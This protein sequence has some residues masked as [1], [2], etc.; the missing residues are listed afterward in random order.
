MQGNNC[1]ISHQTTPLI[2]FILILRYETR[3]AQ[4]DDIGEFFWPWDRFEEKVIRNLQVFK[5]LTMDVFEIWL[6]IG[7]LLLV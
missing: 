1:W 4:C 6:K 3:N 2:K 7:R 5:M